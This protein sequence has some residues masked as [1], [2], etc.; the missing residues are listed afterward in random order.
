MRAR[1]KRLGLTQS[2]VAERSEVSVELVSRI[3]RGR[4]A[5]SLA[6][7]LRLCR[8]LD[9]TPNDVL[10]FNVPAAKDAQMAKM[11]DVFRVLPRPR[12]RELTRIAEALVRYGQSED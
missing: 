2:E 7:L 5:P 8:V 10:G 1:R 9:T 11:V 3:E 6:T 4:C 12:Q